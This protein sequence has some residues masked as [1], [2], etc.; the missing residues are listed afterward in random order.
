MDQDRFKRLRELFQDALELDADARA[1]FLERECTGDEA[2]RAD[3]ERLIQIEQGSGT[4]LET[5]A[6]LFTPPDDAASRLVGTRVG[7]YSI[8]RVIS[9][10]GMG[11]VYEALQERPERIVALK[12]IRQGIVS[13]SASRRFEYEA[14]I[15]ARLHHP[16]IAQVIEAGTHI[17]G[18]EVESGVAVGLPYLVMEFVAGARTITDYAR[19]HDLSTKERL[20]LFIPVCEAVHHGHRQGVIHRDLKP[21]NI[22]V[23]GEGTVKVI[24]F[25]VAR[26]ADSDLTMA[27]MRTEAGQLI[28]T[29]QYM[30][31]E[32]CEAD[33]QGVDTRSD[34][35]ALGVV[36]YELLCEELPYDV[37]QAAILEALRLIR[38]EPPRRPSTIR[39]ALR[40]DMETIV[41]TALEKERGRRYQSVSELS[42][43]IHRYLGGEVI[44]AR[45]AGPLRRT[46]KWVKR[47][48][49]VSSAAGVAAL[50]L[51]AIIGHM[52]LWSYPRIMDEQ[53]RLTAAY[54]Q[55]LSL[56]DVKR[57][58]DLEEE[59]EQLWPAFPERI[60]ELN[61]WIGRAEKLI[62]RL[63]MQEET[64]NALRATA[65]PTE[66]ESTDSIDKQAGVDHTWEF[67]S[68]EAKWQHDTLAELV[69][70]LTSFADPNTGLARNVE[71]RLDFAI[72]LGRSTTAFEEAWARA[73]SAISDSISCP[74]Y[75]G[76]RITPVTGLTPIGRDPDSGLWEFAHLQTGEIPQRNEK[77]RLILT[78]ATGLI[79]V[80]VPGGTYL[81]GENAPMVFHKYTMPNMAPTDQA[82]YGEARWVGVQP[83]FLSKYE[84]TQGQWL[85][86]TG[87][88]PSVRNAPE[89]WADREI[90]LLHPVEAV[91]WNDCTQ[92]LGQLGLRLPEE[93]E[94][95][96]ATRAGTRSAWWTGDEP[97][98]LIGVANLR[99]QNCTRYAKVKIPCEPWDDT[100]ATHAPV[101]SLRPNAFGLHDVCGNVY[102]WCRDAAKV[103]LTA[104][105]DTSAATSVGSNQEHK[106][107]RIHRGGSWLHYAVH[108]RSAFRDAVGAS[109][110]YQDIGVRPAVSLPSPH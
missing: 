73:I 34:V 15:L 40:G 70:R 61:A 99:D 43:D 64:S 16:N 3:V 4:F 36:L 20:D 74:K 108:C 28:G 2:L 7:G 92:V 8:K 38:E 85:H 24:D 106:L 83:F 94:W 33:P 75:A 107:P 91:S 11:V 23:D 52:L 19:E 6:V 89:V 66:V 27:T 49:V 104:S 63:P 110:A 44:L 50:A 31:P 21:S 14:E 30:S 37:E 95:E 88:N 84:M 98:S 60:P 81:M 62:N 59:A 93:M 87:H 25:G 96:Y 78:E 68:D 102:E 10:G 101:G 57:L 42:G 97:E 45:P 12:V 9:S 86:F 67:E 13:R 71:A 54:T 5:P 35:Y 46:W 109:N 103:S 39:R 48:P 55:I 47:N 58:Q 51:L 69:E 22:L 32:Q 76:L 53:R 41:L 1:G 72:K 90:S 56:S 65:R 105:A 80:L 82:G 17:E 77:G 79:F 100:F 18:E 29:L 26:A